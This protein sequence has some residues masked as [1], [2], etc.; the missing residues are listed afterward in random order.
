MRDRDLVRLYWPVEL[1]PAFDALFEL[2][3]TLAEVVKTSTQP[4]L[5][6]IR[7]AWWREALERLDS[8][9]P[10][11]EPRLQAVAAELLPRGISG[12]E[13]AEIEEAFAARLDEHVDPQR[14]ALG[15]ERIFRLAARILGK[16]DA[17]LPAAGRIYAIGRAARDGLMLAAPGEML[18]ALPLRGHRFAGAVRPLTGMTRLAKR[19]LERFPAIEPEATPARAIALLFHR[20]IG[21]IA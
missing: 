3:D 8:A 6:A 2:E 16:E 18:A 10:P 13:L 12:R 17:A 7:L 15:G 4:A 9:P 1:R 20:L 11:P 14:V 5:A 21:T 19:D